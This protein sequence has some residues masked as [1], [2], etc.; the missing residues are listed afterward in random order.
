MPWVTPNMHISPPAA[1]ALPDPPAP[2]PEPP[3]LP[4]RKMIHPRST[5]SSSVIPPTLLC[6]HARETTSATYTP[7]SSFTCPASATR[8]ASFPTPPPATSYSAGSP[9]STGQATPRLATLCPMSRS[10]P[11]PLHRSSCGGRPAA[12]T[13]HLPEKASPAPPPPQPPTEPPR[14]P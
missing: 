1:P 13:G 5:P 14:P 4:T 3:R 10:P 11:R 9:P 6:P 12:Y 2:Q 8:W 7:P